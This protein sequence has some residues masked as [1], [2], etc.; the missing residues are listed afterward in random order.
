VS[1]SGASTASE[2]FHGCPSTKGVAA[3][4]SS[5]MV[6]ASGRTWG[7]PPAPDIT[8]PEGDAWLT[9]LDGTPASSWW[10]SR[11]LE[12]RR[13]S[14]DVWVSSA[15][16]PP[17]TSNGNSSSNMEPVAFSGSIISRTASRRRVTLEP[18]TPRT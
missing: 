18:T 8:D 13:V 10:G 2:S 5:G 4:S 11:R 15:D 17:F 16:D 7:A 3:T 12:S 6:G 1:A 14:I 9:P